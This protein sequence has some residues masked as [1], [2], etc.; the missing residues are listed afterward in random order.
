MILIFLICIL[1]FLLTIAIDILYELEKKIDEIFEKSFKHI[2]LLSMASYFSLML[3]A[4]LL[5]L[6]ILSID[7][8]L[9]LNWFW[10]MI[11][12][13]KNWIF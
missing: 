4:I 10:G 2:N 3:L 6:V 9:I 1:S 11:I 13:C 12:V 7:F 5:T 8:N